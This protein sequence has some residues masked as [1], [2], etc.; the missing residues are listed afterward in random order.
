ME[1][2]SELKGE[3][4]SYTTE[5]R[6]YDPRIGRWL[7]VD[8]A[9]NNFADISPYANNFNNPIAHTD[10]R[11]DCPDGNCGDKEIVAANEIVSKNYDPSKNRKD[12][13]DAINRDL[14]K[15]LVSPEG[16]EMFKTAGDIS[17][18]QALLQSTWEETF[19]TDFLS[20][21]T[22]KAYREAISSSDGIEQKADIIQLRS[23][24]MRAE[25]EKLNLVADGLTTWFIG[26]VGETYP[27]SYNIRTGR[28]IEIPRSTLHKNSNAYVGHQGVY[29]IVKD[30]KLLKYG[31]A[32]MSKLAATGLPKRL[33][34]QLNALQK[35][36]PDSDISGTVIYQNSNIST[37]AIKAIETQ[38]IQTYYNIHKA[39]PPGN[40][41]HP[42]ISK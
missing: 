30:G 8:P 18:F 32:D 38:N 25:M 36:F 35:I 29:Q 1:K 41:G 2:D 39:Y 24:H 33:Q 37:K 22:G 11:G 14:L 3:G 4:N 42:G 20:V 6:Q 34:N 16:K 40:L 7:S 26:M 17:T 15:L 10:P 9:M 27:K 13:S 21:K 31:K 23:V 19:F 28:N 12:I 5:F